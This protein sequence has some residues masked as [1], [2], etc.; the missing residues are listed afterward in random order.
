V[1][2]TIVREKPPEVSAEVRSVQRCEVC[3]ILATEVTLIGLKNDRR[4]GGP[5]WCLAHH[6]ASTPG[7]ISDGSN[8]SPLFASYDHETEG[9]RPHLTLS[10]MYDHLT[11]GGPRRSKQPRADKGRARSRAASVRRGQT[12]SARAPC[13]SQTTTPAPSLTPGTGQRVSWSRS[14]RPQRPSALRSSPGL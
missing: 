2:T 14:L 1:D 13:T 7:L 6:P 4:R 12:N 8:G 3:G 5:R 10:A 11:R 9:E